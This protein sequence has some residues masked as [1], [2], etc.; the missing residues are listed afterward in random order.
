[1]ALRCLR[2]AA[3]GASVL[4]G[5]TACLTNTSS[6][7]SAP[8]IAGAVPPAGVINYH[9]THPEWLTGT[10]TTG[11][12]TYSMS[13][14]AGGDYNQSFQNCVGDNFTSPIANE[15]A[16]HSLALGAVWITYRP[17]LPADQVRLITDRVAQRPFL[18]SSPYPGQDSPISVQA[19]GYQLKV[20]S[21]DDPAIDQFIEAYRIVVAPVPG[22]TCSGGSTELG[23]A[24][25]GPDTGPSATPSASAGGSPGPSGTATPSGSPTPGGSP[26]LSGSA[27]PS[28]GATSTSTGGSTPI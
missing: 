22:A 27:G 23:S 13:P 26:D 24:D 7:T 12:L 28:G 1:V 8:S 2:L 9:L 21:A 6:G 14:P 4:V 20:D 15:R 18:F 16:V 17:D 11:H 10:V 3:V 19:W 25:L 5:T